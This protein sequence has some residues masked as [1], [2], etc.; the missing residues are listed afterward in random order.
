MV[1]DEDSTVSTRTPNQRLSSL[2]DQAGLSNKQLA[3][4]VRETAARYGTNAR[5]THTSVQRWRD[6]R[7]SRAVPPALIAETLSLAL[8]RAVTPADI[9]MPAEGRPRS[10]MDTAFIEAPEE[11]AAA[12]CRL[13]EADLDRSD[14]IHAEL[15]I[16]LLSG[17]ALHWLLAEEAPPVTGHGPGFVP[18]AGAGVGVGAGPG[19][20]PGLEVTQADLGRLRATLQAFEPIMARHGGAVAHRPVVQYLLS[21]LG[22]LLTGSF[23]EQVGRALFGIATQGLLL[24]G[25]CAHESGLPGLGRR[26]HLLALFFAHQADARALGGRALV[27]L[28]GSCSAPADQPAVLD[29]LRAAALGTRSEAGPVRVAVHTAEAWAHAI[30]RDA[31]AT[32]RALAQARRAAAEDGGVGV[33]GGVGVAG[34]GRSGGGGEAAGG[35]RVGDGGADAGVDVPTGRGVAVGTGAFAGRGEDE[36]GGGRGQVAAGPGPRSGEPSV[37]ARVAQDITEAELRCRVAL[38][39]QTAARQ[40]AQEVLTALGPADTVRTVVVHGLLATAQL[41]SGL[42]DQ[43][44]DT[45]ERAL[46]QS[47]GL[48]SAAVDNRLD[49][50]ADELAALEYGGRPAVLAKLIREQLHHRVPRRRGTDR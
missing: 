30:L 39:E 37:R 28:A 44:C 41:R 18:G 24:A 8:G 36:G 43:A 1:S 29:L 19:L 27:A 50:L 16:G 6:G 38:G 33:G 23:T 14:L 20:G 26:Y 34:R 3:R 46:W 10:P 4:A 49:A 45:A 48:Q 42:T 17:P 9:G 13:W 40:C 15:P 32:D 21:D 35:G 31:A 12:A 11:L 5:C 22:R 2:I 7:R 47:A 25:T